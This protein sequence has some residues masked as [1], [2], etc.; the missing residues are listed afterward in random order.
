MKDGFVKSIFM[1]I[2]EIIL[3]ICWHYDK[4]CHC[5]KCKKIS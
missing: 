1:K 3:Q 2:I 4:N 5:L